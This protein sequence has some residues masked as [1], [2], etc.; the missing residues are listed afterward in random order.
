MWPRFLHVIVLLSF[1]ST[2]MAP[3]ASLFRNA[4]NTASRVPADRE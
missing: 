2:E 4:A 3:R 1:Y